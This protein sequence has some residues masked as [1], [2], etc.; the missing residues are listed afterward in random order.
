MKV[1][2]I[3]RWVPLV[4]AILFACAMGTGCGLS[5]RPPAPEGTD[6]AEVSGEELAEECINNLRQIDAAKEQWALVHK[7]VTGD[8]I[9]KWDVDRYMEGGGPKCPA[10]GKYTYGKIGELP[11]C[12]VT[13][14]VLED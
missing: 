5:P 2:R 3:A 13:G 14:H 4:C 8:K 7:K 12:S 11:K 1:N 9:V 6:D 10:G